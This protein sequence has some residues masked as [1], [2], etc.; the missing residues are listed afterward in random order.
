M[1]LPFPKKKWS[2]QEWDQLRGI[3][4]SKMIALLNKDT[5]WEFLG[6]KGSRYIYRNSEL[7]A[8]FDHVAIHFHPKEGYRD[9]KLLRAILDHICW[10]RDDLVKWKVIK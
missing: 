7:R 2:K 4:K 5:R 8:P 6:T 10:T 9:Q 1:E 3:T